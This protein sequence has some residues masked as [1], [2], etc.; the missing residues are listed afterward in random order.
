MSSFFKD[1]TIR[2]FYLPLVGALLSL[3][4]SIIYISGYTGSSYFHI[5]AFLFPLI[6]SILFFGMIFLKWTERFAAL[7]LEVFLFLG[8]LF[9]I[10]FVYLYLSTVFYDGIKPEA[11]ANL[12]PVFV[13]TLLFELVGIV[14]ANFGIYVKPKKV[15]EVEG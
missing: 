2:G 15:L 4:A 3:A 7:A 12:S 6:G 1:R 9:F 14:L 11:I 10:R 8:F 5:T 13:L